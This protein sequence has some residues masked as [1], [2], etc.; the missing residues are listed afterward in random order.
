ME[1]SEDGV[2]VRN[3]APASRDG[4]WARSTLQ[5]WTGWRGWDEG[6]DRSLLLCHL[7]RGTRSLTMATAHHAETDSWRALSSRARVDV[8]SSDRRT[9]REPRR[10]RRRF[11]EPPRR[12]Y[13]ARLLLRAESKSL[14]VIREASDVAIPARH[15]HDNT[16]THITSIQPTPVA[17]QPQHR[18]LPSDVRKRTLAVQY[19]CPA[20]VAL[21]A[22]AVLLSASPFAKSWAAR[23]RTTRYVTTCLSEGCALIDSEMSDLVSAQFDPCV[24]FY[25]YVCSSWTQ[26]RDRFSSFVDDQRVYAKAATVAYMLD[27]ASKE[28]VLQNTVIASMASIYN[29]CASH[30]AT[31]KSLDA[32]A[33]EVLCALNV[34]R[35]T[36]MNSTLPGVLPRLV[37]FSLLYRLH[38]FFALSYKRRAAPLRM[39][40]GKVARNIS[41]AV[42][43]PDKLHSYFETMLVVFDR[44]AAAAARYGLLR[45]LVKLDGA[46]HEATKMAANDAERTLPLEQLDME[47]IPHE[48]W[49]SSVNS[50]FS[51]DSEVSPTT[52]VVVKSIDR[53]RD[54]FSVLAGTDPEVS[55]TYLLVLVTSQ[56]IRYEFYERY[57]EVEQR[58]G[59]VYV[60]CTEV[61]SRLFPMHYAMMEATALRQ[62]NHKNASASE[63]L[64]EVKAYLIVI[65]NDSSAIDTAA[66]DAMREQLS[67]R[68]IVI[69]DPVNDSE[70]LAESDAVFTQS[71]IEN[72]FNAARQE[73]EEDAMNKSRWPP[74]WRMLARAQWHGSFS[75]IEDRGAIVI[76]SQNFV[77]VTQFSSEIFGDVFSYAVLLARFV[78]ELLV[79]VSRDLADTDAYAWC[80]HRVNFASKRQAVEM[81]REVKSLRVAY[82]AY[83]QRKHLWDG[84]QDS[85]LVTSERNFFQA[86]CV[87]FCSHPL[88]EP[89]PSLLRTRHRCEIS[90]RSMPE[91]WD[92]YKCQEE[93]RKRSATLDC[94]VAHQRR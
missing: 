93:L 51:L 74:N 81:L 8:E 5:P 71:Y 15:E 61:L 83:K 37:E 89:T 43:S 59:W 68:D 72:M 34:R 70:F 54:A 38:S 58:V 73:A 75:Y 2:A 31:R 45:G 14:P 36:W 26:A 90:V 28:S 47:G 60:A 62:Q 48:L 6:D 9:T 33:G 1:P 69:V 7:R 53:L 84:V 50:A 88:L 12:G 94:L 44:A 13:S 27:L 63:L 11:S 57:A 24:D 41:A 35:E 29:G 42:Y 10:R 17:L 49:A 92:A 87:Q 64:E 3:G 4:L 82:Q 46:V 67:I 77:S 85:G 21:C 22:A 91:F 65:L 40:V 66:K 56:A 86:F 16:T 55:S 25:D 20:V 39:T 78:L 79:A 32:I 76:A 19:R 52:G 80:P 30:F 23:R 18:N